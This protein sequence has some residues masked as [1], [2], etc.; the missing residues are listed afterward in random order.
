MTAAAIARP[1]VSPAAASLLFS[2]GHGVALWAASLSSISVASSGKK[3][4]RTTADAAAAALAGDALV[5]APSAAIIALYCA[6]DMYV[7]MRICVVGL[8]TA[9]ATKRSR[10]V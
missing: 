6:T 7:R 9:R 4:L 3:L 1:I 10:V 8:P 5:A 2:P